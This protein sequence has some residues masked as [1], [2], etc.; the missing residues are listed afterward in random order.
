MVQVM[1]KQVHCKKRINEHQTESTVERGM[2][3]RVWYDKPLVQ[4]SA[5]SQRV[6]GRFTLASIN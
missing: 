5:A 4:L 1:E 3:Y 2:K 6:M